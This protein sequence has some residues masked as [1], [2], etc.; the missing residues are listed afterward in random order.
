MYIYFI[1]E[2]PYE[3]NLLKGQSF[4]SY[5]Y[6]YHFK[7]SIQPEPN[8]VDELEEEILEYITNNPVSCHFLLNNFFI[9]CNF[10]YSSIIINCLTVNA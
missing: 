4:L 2:S 10:C 7:L 5:V 3:E 6:Y 1:D 9:L 8:I